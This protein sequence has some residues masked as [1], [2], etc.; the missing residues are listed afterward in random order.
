MSEVS[1]TPETISRFR[2]RY[3]QNFGAARRDDA[4]YAAVSE[5]RR[6]AGMEHWLPL[7]YEKLDTFFDFVPSAPVVYEHLAKEAIAERRK[8]VI[9]HFDARRRQADG[10]TG[11][12]SL[13]YM[14][15]APD[16]LYLDTDGI[17]SAEAGRTRVQLSPFRSI[18]TGRDVV[19]DAGALRGRNFAAERQDTSSS[20]FEAAVSHIGDLRRPDGKCWSAHGPKAR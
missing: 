9:D 7:F 8:L 5:G 13:P 6:F 10:Q 18:E 16:L 12:E 11:S 19:L 17:E 4:L 1:L 14:P 3:I 20:V 15:V 2:S